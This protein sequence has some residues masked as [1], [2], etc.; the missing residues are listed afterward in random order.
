VAGSAIAL[1]SVLGVQ[2]HVVIYSCPKPYPEAIRRCSQQSFGGSGGNGICTNKSRCRAWQSRQ[3]G[4]TTSAYA[5]VTALVHACTFW[6]DV[7]PPGCFTKSHQIRLLHPSL[8]RI[9]CFLHTCRRRRQKK[10]SDGPQLDK[11]YYIRTV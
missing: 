3:T 4:S 1:G 6:G 7:Q 10:V 11:F 2:R 5:R 8:P 9:R